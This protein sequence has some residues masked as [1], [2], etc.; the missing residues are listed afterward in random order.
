MAALPT[1]DRVNM[2]E[3][4]RNLPPLETPRLL[5]RKVRLSD[6]ADIF[7]FASDPAVARY[8]TWPPHPTVVATEAFVRELL[9]RYAQGLVAP[10]G[11]VHRD[12]GRMI[13]SCGFAYVMAWHGRAE[14]A[15][16]LS[17]AYWGRGLMPEAL[18]AVLAFGFETLQLN[19]IEARCEVENHASERVMQKVGM[20]FE[21]V[22][23]QHAQVMGQYRDLKLY[24]MLRQEWPGPAAITAAR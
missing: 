9:Q 16:A 8:T 13:G 21:G 1:P 19:R 18:R 10:W 12:D 22:L 2:D 7:A 24:S 20:Q 14:I 5:L 6:A 11:I 15:Y 23:R 17:P 4:F 3:I